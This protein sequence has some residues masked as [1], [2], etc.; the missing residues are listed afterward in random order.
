MGMEERTK[1]EDSVLNTIEFDFERKNVCI[2]TKDNS[3]NPDI[4]ADFLR[5]VFKYPDDL[6]NKA[7]SELNTG[8]KRILVGPFSAD[9]AKTFTYEATCLISKEK[10]YDNYVV[11]VKEDS[12]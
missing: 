6:V 5:I 7:V 3:L 10:K 1:K 9:V 4:Y 11:Y 12:I 8:D 2:A